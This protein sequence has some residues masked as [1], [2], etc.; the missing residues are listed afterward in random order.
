VIVEMLEL[1][2]RTL[3]ATIALETELTDGLP[4]IEIDRVQFE[5]ALLNLVVNA[6][7][8]MPNGGGLVIRTS[9]SRACDD[10]WPE[11]IADGEQADF[12]VVAVCDTGK[13]M[14]FEVQQRACEPF[15]TTKE[16]GQG[17]GLG[18][19]TV[20]GF[21]EQSG[22]RLEISSEP[23]DGTKIHLSFPAAVHAEELVPSH[24]ATSQS[25]MGSPGKV[26]LVEDIDE[27]RKVVA[28]QLERLG[29][30]V[31]QARNGVEAL[32]ML[33]S[34]SNFDLVLTDITMPG[35]IQGTMLAE[36]ASNELPHLKIILMTGNPSDGD[37]D[38]GGLSKRVP[39]LTKP[40]AM[41]DLAAVVRAELDN[42]EFADSPRIRE[43]HP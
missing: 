25:S 29:H 4:Q 27:V 31:S 21:V 19:A 22:G 18:L 43:L 36:I 40:V 7:D 16:I 11:S 38:L 30:F 42:R 15:F 9:G 14:S 28:I 17:S 39:R 13:G 34:S 32:Q 20:Y 1:F 37:H 3:P 23:G 41:S 24:K 26:L 2:Q 33:R 35:E 12:V 8:A 6:R 5:S 10:D